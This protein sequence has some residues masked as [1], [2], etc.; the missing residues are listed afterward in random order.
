[1]GTPANAIAYSSGYIKLKDLLVPGAVL[2]IVS[3]LV[4]LLM[5]KFYWP[6]LGMKI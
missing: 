6:I 3:L 2:G 4:F 5:V 1:M